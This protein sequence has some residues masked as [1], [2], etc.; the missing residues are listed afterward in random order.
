MLL[1]ASHIQRA[2][3]EEKT[4][5]TEK[6]CCFCRMHRITRMEKQME[7][8]GNCPLGQSPLHYELEYNNLKAFWLISK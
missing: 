8:V 1:E 2:E 6:I 5:I 3:V 7:A 4:G